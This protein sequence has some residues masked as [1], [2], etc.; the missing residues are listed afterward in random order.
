M[1]YQ[2]YGERRGMPPERAGAA[3]GVRTA[4]GELDAAPAGTRGGGGA[5]P[6]MR[7]RPCRG[8]E[9]EKLMR[10]LV[11]TCA[12]AFH[13]SGRVF[14]GATGPCVG[15]ICGARFCAHRPRSLKGKRPSATHVATRV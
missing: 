1:G 3:R 11:H 9:E 8:R 10:A 2:E 7:Q 5:P 6:G 12:A 15:A 13:A 4:D 14:C